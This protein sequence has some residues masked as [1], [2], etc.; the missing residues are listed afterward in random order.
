MSDTVNNEVIGFV[1]FE[2]GKTSNDATIKSRFSGM[3]WTKTI[4]NLNVLV[5]GAGGIGSWLAMH[6]ARVGVGRI[7]I[8]DGDKAECVNMSGQLIPNTAIGRYKSDVVSEEI[9]RYC[10]SVNIDSCP[11]MFTSICSMNYDVVFCAVDNMNARKMIAKKID[12]YSMKDKRPMMFIDG[13]LSV[14][15]LQVYNV[16][17]NDN[18]Q[19]WEYIH[20]KNCMF[21]DHE[22]FETICNMKQTSYMANMI[23]VIMTNILVNAIS[24]MDDEHACE[25]PFF[26]KY[27]SNDMNFTKMSYD[28]WLN[29]Y[30]EE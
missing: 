17:C 27:S 24:S 23:G 25:I 5:V 6:L 14:D 16:I 3:N 29:E 7:T 1:D 26:V 21:D 8:Y 20:N 13:R 4:S 18:D 10:G 22:A 15:E 19:L 12:G 28:E 11:S 30:K 9:V 2:S